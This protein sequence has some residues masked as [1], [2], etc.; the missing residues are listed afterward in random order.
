M[1]GISHCGQWKLYYR[2]EEEKLGHIPQSGVYQLGELWVR[3]GGSSIRADN[4]SFPHMG[5][6]DYTI[7]CQGNGDPWGVILLKQHNL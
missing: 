6:H 5:Y 4:I 2:V 1:N 3:G 7:G